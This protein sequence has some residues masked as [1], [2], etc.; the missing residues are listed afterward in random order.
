[1]IHIRAFIIIFA[2][3]VSERGGALRRKKNVFK[4]TKSK[5]GNIFSGLMWLLQIRITPGF[6]P[7]QNGPSGSSPGD[8]AAIVSLE[9]VK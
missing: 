9:I 7:V 4:R 8:A 6:V 2:D 5:F 3:V 1:M